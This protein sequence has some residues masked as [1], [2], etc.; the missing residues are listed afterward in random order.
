MSLLRTLAAPI[1]R[2]ANS[3]LNPV[4]EGAGR[5]LLFHDIPEPQEAAFDRLLDKLTVVPPGQPSGVSLSFDDGFISNHKI[6]MEILA[7]RNIKALFFIC[8]GLLALSGE[9][10]LES[11]SENIMRGRS[12]APEPLM[13]WD[14]IKE[15]HA[16][17][18]T[19]GA[20]TLTHRD[21]TTLDPKQL[22]Q[23]ILASGDAISERLDVPVDWFAYP[24]GEIG[25]IDQQSMAV[26]RS[27][28][29][30]CRSGVRGLNTPQTSP[31]GLH[32]EHIDLT[33][34][35][36]YQMLAAEGGLDRRYTGARARLAQLAG[37]PDA[38]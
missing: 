26:I 13:N 6:A 22:N 8:P 16:A 3:L 1:L 30:F 14:Q 9:D 32:A 36:A 19:I 15:L 29:R 23:E 12:V 31:Y 5:I 35:L 27:R 33:A 17:G 24:F 11:V 2:S 38:V 10:Q 25:N 4:P 28:Y 21:L 37:K 34:S 20:H 18:H 7:R